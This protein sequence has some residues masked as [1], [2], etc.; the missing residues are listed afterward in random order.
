[1]TASIVPLVAGPAPV[2]P[3][4]RPV[5]PPALRAPDTPLG[6]ARLV[7]GWS[8][9]KVVRALMLLADHWGWEIAAEKSL[10]VFISRWENDT[11]RPS[12]TYQVLL[13]AIF[14]AT[15]AEL[16]FTRPAAATTLTQRVTALESVIEDLT[17]RLGEVAA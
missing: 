10:K 5:Q 11:H 15:P 1:M 9:I 3:S 14:R 7:R 12:Q 4:G 13:C 16:G 17:G 8:Q 6:R 2:Q